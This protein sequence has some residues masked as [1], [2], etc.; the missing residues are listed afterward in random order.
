MLDHNLTSHA[1]V[2]LKYREQVL[3]V[4]TGKIQSKLHEGIVPSEVLKKGHK[5]VSSENHNKILIIK[6]QEKRKK[7]NTPIKEVPTNLQVS[8][9]SSQDADIDQLCS[10]LPHVMET[11]KKAGHAESYVKLN[12]LL[13]TGE[14][15]LDNICF[16]LLL[17]LIEWFSVHKTALHK[18][19]VFGK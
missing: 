10:L 15:P 13:A 6:S 19:C 1:D 8:D 11:L 7:L 4:G 16:L 14:M 2:T 18:Q 3:N 17:D 12:Q 5:I 9:T